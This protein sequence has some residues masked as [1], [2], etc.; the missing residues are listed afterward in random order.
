MVNIQDIIPW[1]G[2]KV[3]RVL[4]GDAV[5]LVAGA[6]ALT[7]AVAGEA[8]LLFGVSRVEVEGDS[9]GE[10]DEDGED[11]EEAQHSW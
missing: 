10:G 11:D 8:D 9:G 6:I 1:I 2:A 3:Q 5:G 4:P 7:V